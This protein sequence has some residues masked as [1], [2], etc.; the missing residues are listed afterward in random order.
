GQPIPIGTSVAIRG[1][2]P[3]TSTLSTGVNMPSLTTDSEGNYA[4]FG[5][6]AGQYIVDAFPNQLPNGTA[7]GFFPLGSLSRD[8]GVAV[9]VTEGA[10]TTA[11]F[12]VVGFSGGA[13]PRVISGTL[14][15][16]NGNPIRNA[17]AFLSEPHALTTNRVF[18]V[19]HDGSFAINGLVPGK[20]I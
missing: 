14:K 2:L 15:D 13:S 7:G 1:P 3:R 6:P 18:F 5:L 4:Y 8:T 17:F 10:S 11:D 16:P 12:Q 19:N 20:Y 9:A